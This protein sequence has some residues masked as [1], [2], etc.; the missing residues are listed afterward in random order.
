MLMGSSTHFT[1]S[2]QLGDLMKREI[3]ENII[4]G[5]SIIFLFFFFFVSDRQEVN[6]GNVIITGEYLDEVDPTKNNTLF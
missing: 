2:Q 5:S 3:I 6:Q 1:N 4:I